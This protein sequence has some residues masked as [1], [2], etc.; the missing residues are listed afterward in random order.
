M[1]SSSDRIIVNVPSCFVVPPPPKHAPQHGVL[2]GSITPEM[3]G[4]GLKESDKPLPFLVPWKTHTDVPRVGEG[5]K[6]IPVM[7]DPKVLTKAHERYETAETTLASVF[8]SH[9]DGEKLT[10]A[11]LQSMENP[12]ASNSSP[13]VWTLDRRVYPN[14]PME[15]KLGGKKLKGESRH[16]LLLQG[17]PFSIRCFGEPGGVG[18]RK[19]MIYGP[20]GHAIAQVDFGHGDSCGIHAHALV[21]GNLAHTPSWQEDHLFHLRSVPWAWTVIPEVSAE[22]VAELLRK[23]QGAMNGGGGADVTDKKKNESD[24]SDGDSDANSMLALGAP[25]P[26]TRELDKMDGWVKVSLPFEDFMGSGSVSF[27]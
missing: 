8:K 5:S 14:P 7:V 23:K 6:L 16:K 13:I 27:E 22:T 12:F 24:D 19:N 3:L 2:P 26:D 17:P 20:D 4:I 11:V 21:Q 15:K 1:S 10:A 25:L 18:P 9:P